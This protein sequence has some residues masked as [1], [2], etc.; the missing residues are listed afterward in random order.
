M[1]CINNEKTVR[2]LIDGI[3]EIKIDASGVKHIG[4]TKNIPSWH[5]VA[6]DRDKLKKDGKYSYRDIN[7]QDIKEIRHGNRMLY[8]AG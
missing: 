5:V 1:K 7:P 3:G 8:K 6:S 2:V 4:Y